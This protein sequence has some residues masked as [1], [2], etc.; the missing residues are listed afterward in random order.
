[1]YALNTVGKGEH[2]LPGTDIRTLHGRIPRSGRWT[3]TL[4]MEATST[5]GAVPDWLGRAR[6]AAVAAGMIEAHIAL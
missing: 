4:M 6:A 2:V 3:A 5:V 1:V